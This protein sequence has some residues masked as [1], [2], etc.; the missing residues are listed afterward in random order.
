MTECFVAVRPQRTS[1]HTEPGTA[2]GLPALPKKGGRSATACHDPSQ[3]ASS[4]TCTCCPHQGR[5]FLSL[6]KGGRAQPLQP[7]T[8][9]HPRGWLPKLVTQPSRTQGPS[10]PAPALSATFSEA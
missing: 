6:P 8:L 10:I 3:P 1:P 5:L 9:P 2:A 4:P 7:L